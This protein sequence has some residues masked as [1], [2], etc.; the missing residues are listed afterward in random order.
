[1]EDDAVIQASSGV[2][3][4]SAQAPGIDAILVC[5]WFR[6]FGFEGDGSRAT[7][8]ISESTS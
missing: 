2:H 3:V 6:W 1:M 4:V 5:I 8:L 7:S